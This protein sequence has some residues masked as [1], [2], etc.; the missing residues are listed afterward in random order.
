MEI[1]SD[2]VILQRKLEDLGVDFTPYEKYKQKK[3]AKGL[4]RVQ[5]YC[6][7]GHAGHA[8]T[9]LVTAHRL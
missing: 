2:K 6:I 7:N 9:K 5:L 8:H 1:V 3:T 4:R